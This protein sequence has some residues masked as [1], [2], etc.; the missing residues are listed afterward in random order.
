MSGNHQ[1]SSG[2]LYAVSA[3]ATAALLTAALGN[4]AALLIP[5][6]QI[7]DVQ[8]A[9]LDV[10]FAEAMNRASAQEGRFPNDIAHHSGTVSM[11]AT[12]NDSNY[13]IICGT[14][15]GITPTTQTVGGVTLTAYPIGQSTSPQPVMII[16]KTQNTAGKLA[17][18][19]WTRAY[20]KSFSMPFKQ[21]GFV[22]IPLDFDAIAD[23]NNAGIVV[24]PY[25]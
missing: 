21:D 23:A 15:W 14:C 3:P 1:F 17:L 5:A 16:F 10:A 6:N 24:T 2:I 19:V 25:Q 13:G 9:G 22:S 8:D 7:A 20:L 11:K 12:V 4:L 18:I